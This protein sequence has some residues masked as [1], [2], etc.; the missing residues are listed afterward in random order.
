MQSF[1]EERV[2]Y[3]F[4]TFGEL[5]QFR[6]EHKRAFITFKN[7][8]DVAKVLTTNIHSVKHTQLRVFIYKDPY[9]HL[10]API[11]L[12]VDKSNVEKESDTTI[13][14]LNDDCLLEIMERLDIVQLSKMTKINK[15]FKSIAYKV[16]SRK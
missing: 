11:S 15:R 14:Q 13:M 7:K 6:Y 9:H 16:F 8:K 12:N 5:S 10:N 2:K 3:Y 1:S 4:E